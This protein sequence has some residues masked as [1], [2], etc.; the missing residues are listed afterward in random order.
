MHVV[1]R[2][3]ELRHQFAE[4]FPEFSF[5]G[6]HECSLCGGDENIL[7]GSHVNLFI[8][9]DDV[10]YLATGRVDHYIEVHGYAPPPKFMDAVLNCPDPRS[11]RYAAVLLGLNRGERPPLFPERWKIFKVDETRVRSRVYEMETEEEAQKFAEMLAAK[12]QS[13]AYEIERVPDRWATED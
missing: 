2:L 8:P 5:R 1:E 7:R 11:A 4:A 10:M 12:D 3:V 13:H 9:G 6:L